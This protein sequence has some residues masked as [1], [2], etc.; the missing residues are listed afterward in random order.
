MAEAQRRTRRAEPR[1]AAVRN[2]TADSARAVTPSNTS[3]AAR[4]GTRPVAPAG[5]PTGV[6][7]RIVSH[8]PG[9]LRVRVNSGS[10][11][12]RSMHQLGRRL[13]GALGPGRV[14]VSPATGS[15]LVRYDR[16]ANS[17]ADIVSI[18]HDIGVVI[19]ETT[20]GVEFDP[21]EAAG[22]HSITGD[23]IV[24]GVT[25][26]DRQLSALTG[27]KI[28]LKVLFPLT[29]GGL[30]LWRAASSGLGLDQVPA[31]V[32]LWYAFDSFWKFHNTSRPDPAAAGHT[33]AEPDG[34]P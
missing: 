19:E 4:S 26:L 3:R 32:M 24:D 20:R 28:D 17:S 8:T 23:R 22:T 10:R 33:E 25:D 16:Q 5:E 31:W 34:A 14:E 30:G 1:Q 11:E 7:A 6:R 18:L 12:P 9:R 27:R 29:L 21:S 15:V 13:Q 2:A